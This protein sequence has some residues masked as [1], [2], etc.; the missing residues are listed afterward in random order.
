MNTLF[1]MIARMALAQHVFRPMASHY[2]IKKIVNCPETEQPAEILVDTS[3]SATSK[4][5]KKPAAIR[6]CSLWP[7]RKGCTQSC[8]R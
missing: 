5:K 6:N 1:M 3:P 8:L 4:L 7:A 2:R